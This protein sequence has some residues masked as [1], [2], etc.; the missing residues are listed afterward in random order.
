MNLLNQTQ[1]AAALGFSKEF[2]SRKV[3]EGK[4]TPVIRLGKVYRFDLTKVRDELEQAAKF[5]A[6][7]EQ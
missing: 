3:K 6:T 2:V 5:N 4:I 1:L 7:T